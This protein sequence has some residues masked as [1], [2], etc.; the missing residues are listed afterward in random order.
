MQLQFV[1]VGMPWPAM[2]KIMRWHIE[3]DGEKKIT[4]ITKIK[5]QKIEKDT[6]NLLEGVQYSI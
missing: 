2:I 6:N 1:Q 5:N 4:I 3:N